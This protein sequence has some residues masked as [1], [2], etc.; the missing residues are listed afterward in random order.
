MSLPCTERRGGDAQVVDSSNGKTTA[1]TG[2]PA[3]HGECTSPVFRAP[4]PQ[5]QPALRLAALGQIHLDGSRDPQVPVLETEDPVGSDRGI[6]R[7][8]E[9][10][11]AAHAHVVDVLAVGAAVQERR[12]RAAGLNPAC[13]SAA[14]AASSVAE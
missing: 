1:W 14:F 6:A 5:A 11:W 3:R 8:V 4:H 13:A 9:I 2:T 7:G 12:K 10:Q